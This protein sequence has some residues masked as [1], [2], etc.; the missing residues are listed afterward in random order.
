MIGKTISRYKILEKLGEGG[1]GVVYK[2]ED[3][4]LR[5][6][7]ALKF[8]PP[9]ALTSDEEKARFLH[10]AQSSASLDHPNICTIYEISQAGEDT[11]IAMAHV[12]GESL[13]DRLDSGRLMKV[14]D[15]IDFAIQIAEGLHEAHSKGI[16]HR[17]IKSANIMVTES[18]RVKIMD[19]GLAKSPRLTASEESTTLGTVA[20][21]SPEQTRGEDVDGRA[22]I[23][24]LGVVL[25][26]MVTGE[27]PFKG[28]YE[29]A[30]V[31]SILNQE[32]EPV[33]AMRSRIPVELEQII[34][35]TLDKNVNRRYRDV[36]ELITDLRRLKQYI[37]GKASSPN[38]PLSKPSRKRN[39]LRFVVGSV[40]VIAF[41]ALFLS[42][43]ISKRSSQMP[44]P[45]IESTATAEWKNSIAVL[46]FRDFSPD[47]DQEYFCAGMTEAIIGKLSGLEDLK[48]ISMTSVMQYK[49][50]DRDIS[51]IGDALDVI[52]ILEGSIQKEANRIRLRAQLINV[53]DDSHAWSQTYDRDQESVFAIQDEISRAIVDVLKIR[54]LGDD[55]AT[56][57]KRFTD[58][59]EAYNAYVQGRFLWN[60]RTPEHLEKSI[61]Y[62]T[63]AIELDSSY[64]L[65]YAGLADAYAV[66]PD[67]TDIPLDEVLSKAKQAASKALEL[68][69]ELAEAHTSMGLIHRWEKD[70]ENSEK[71]FLLATKLNPGYSYAHYWYSLTLQDM[72]RSEDRYREMEI[73]YELNPLSIVIL[74]NLAGRKEATG[75]SREAEELLKKSIEIE[76]MRANS[77]GKY[78]GFLTRKG[79][80]NE[81]I[82]QYRK[83][84]EYN[85]RAYFLYAS[86]ANIYSGND[87]IENAV[88]TI[89]EY[90]AQEH[91]Q[92]LGYDQLGDIYTYHGMFVEA[93]ESYRKA[94]QLKPEA[95]RIKL[96]RLSLQL[97]QGNYAEA[98]DISLELLS[99]DQQDARSSARLALALIPYAQGKFSKAMRVL[100]DGIEQ[101]EAEEIEN[102]YYAAKHVL[103]GFIYQE[104]NKHDLALAEL[105][106][107]MEIT[108]ELGDNLYDRHTHIQFL[109]EGG[110]FSRAEEEAATLVEDFGMF[111]GIYLYAAGYIDFA[112]GDYAAAENHFSAMLPTTIDLP[113]GSSWH[114][115]AHFIM[116][117]T[118]LELKK[119][120]EAIRGFNKLA[121]RHGP[122][123]L[124]VIR[125]SARIPYY[126]GIAYAGA[127]RNDEAIEQFEKFLE[128]WK[129]TE[130]N[131]E[132]ISD[133]ETRLARLRARI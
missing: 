80:I 115:T 78:A 48:V 124:I 68:D 112:K 120:G 85:P 73:S 19:F 98:E 30:V 133:A 103:L 66:I 7:V 100:T 110:Y 119:F 52:Y 77:Y 42:Y 26:E 65:A 36:L 91:E 21:M 123:K 29:Q 3:M 9:G 92:E 81:G 39:A 61:E 63:R 53:A 55:K 94:L 102:P 5:R 113:V 104:M 41:V 116:A 46:P 70:F 32:P 87:D 125:W 97:V 74:Q 130:L 64:A 47:K 14:N 49:D 37:D 58:N 67:H 4:E 34:N 114:F 51:E 1:M 44:A 31:Y 90:L 35:K 22:D 108:K 95:F 28:D 128:S 33:T 43:I 27:R 13:R 111:F 60:K 15:A 126:L 84:M 96:D 71:E 109:A 8:L 129:D 54:L 69:S 82:A 121:N 75:K 38:I 106:R 105:E 127:G 50:T 20:Y 17:D 18:G 11:F 131:S 132:T 2:A 107:C 25:Y 6:T 117:W 45:G 79:S 10:E 40:V 122:G 83:G 118:Q 99:S 93:E 24:S 76:P 12:T 89:N 57:T 16:V 23:W 56:I 59:V 72:D 86:V 88:K 62:F 101:D